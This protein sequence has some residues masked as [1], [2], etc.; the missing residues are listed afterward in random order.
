LDDVRRV[1]SMR[2]ARPEATI[3]GL[4]I[5]MVAVSQCGI[6]SHGAQARGVGKMRRQLR[7]RSSPALLIPTISEAKL[8]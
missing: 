5:A 7:I 8:L 2:I 3:A 1:G 6:A 4:S